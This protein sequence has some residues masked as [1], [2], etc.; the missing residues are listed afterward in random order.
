MCM[1]HRKPVC[2]V[3]A[4]NWLVTHDRIGPRVLELVESR[5]GLEVELY[6]VGSSG[7]ALLDH[8][9]G[10]DLMIV[11]D[12]GMFHGKAG[13]IRTIEP[14]LRAPMPQV[15]SMHQIGPLETLAIANRL[16]PQN[17]PRRVLL[18]IVETNLIDDDTE[19]AACREVVTVLDREIEAWELSRFVEQSPSES[20]A[21]VEAWVAGVVE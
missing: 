9:H 19:E 18:I 16:F 10:Q 21:S 8:L 7:L 13:E 17:M 6:D 4:G 14:D 1:H 12:A 11:V 15:S 3:G 20:D 5:Y 2:V